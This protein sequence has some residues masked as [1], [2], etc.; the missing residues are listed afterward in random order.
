MRK[1][2]FLLLL[3][4]LCPIFLTAQYKTVNLDF[5][6]AYIG[7]NNPLPA[8]TNILFTGSIPSYIDRIELNIL[9]AKGKSAPLHTAV[10]QR[11][12][13]NKEKTYSLPV[14]YKFRSSSN[15]DIEVRYFQTLGTAQR[16]ELIQ[17]LNSRLQLF[18]ETQLTQDTKM[19][20]WENKPKRLLADMNDLLRS[21]LQNYRTGI[22]APEQK[23]SGLVALQMEKMSKIR[24]KD[25]TARVRMAEEQVLLRQLL[26]DELS[27]ILPAPLYKMVDARYLDD[28]PTESK[29]GA[30]AVTAGY[31]GVY[32]SGDLGE[33]LDYD[34]APFVGLS[35]PL[36]NRA[37]APRFFSN[38]YLGFGVFLQDF[39]NA[40]KQNLT[41]PITGLPIYAS[42]DYKLFQFVYLN[43][44][45]TFLEETSAGDRQV[46]FVRPFIGFSAKVNL[47]V[48]FE[49]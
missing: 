33:D 37:F 31:G 29:K 12:L 24:T 17:T 27:R 21:D 30:L 41:G 48:Q 1:L 39:E 22:A 19:I 46:L 35:F 26:K 47:S 49:R 45:A 40:D 10:W 18:L 11:P 13:D 44:G 2:Q 3:L 25:S 36:G 8:E 15:Y 6:S 5:E 23:L 28:C 9:S 34:T 16:Q 14:N 38:T 7:D 20:E 4:F 42:L 43:L 32:F